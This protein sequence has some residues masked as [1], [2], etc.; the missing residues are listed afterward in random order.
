MDQP[1]TFDNLI[2]ASVTTFERCL[3]SARFDAVISSTPHAA[4]RDSSGADCCC[5]DRPTTKPPTA[6]HIVD[7]YGLS[8]SATAASID[9]HRLV[10]LPRQDGRI[11]ATASQ[12]KRP[13][14][15]RDLFRDRRQPDASDGANPAY[16]SFG[17]NLQLPL[18]AV[19]DGVLVHA[20]NS[21]LARASIGCAGC[22]REAWG[23]HRG[24]RSLSH[25]LWLTC[26][27]EL[28]AE[29]AEASRA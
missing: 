25:Q 15:I 24:D 5:V 29:A 20:P 16:I 22:W 10:F 4:S 2:R 26:S 11:A 3:C 21:R 27:I 9:V 23:C 17:R 28:V 1:H 18:I 14:R 7:L 13:G 12:K 6:R 8:E 19:G